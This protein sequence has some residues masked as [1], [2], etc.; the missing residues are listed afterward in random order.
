MVVSNPARCQSHRMPK[1]VE[2]DE[3][4]PVKSDKC[5]GTS[6]Q[7]TSHETFSFLIKNEIGTKARED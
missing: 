7:E 5:S 3:M 4:K 1:E 2:E 6:F